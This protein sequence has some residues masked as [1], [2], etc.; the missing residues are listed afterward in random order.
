MTKREFMREKRRAI[1]TAIE[2][3]DVLRCG[4][5]CDEYFPEPDFRTAVYKMQ[6]A[7]ITM[8]SIIKPL[9]R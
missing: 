6:E 4:C 1:K 7:I 3:L 2:S 8:D 5:A 9:C